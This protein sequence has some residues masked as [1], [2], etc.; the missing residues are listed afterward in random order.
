MVLTSTLWSFAWTE[1]AEAAFSRL[2]VLFTTTP[3]L[4]HPDPAHQF[5]VEVDASD[6]GVGA[7]LLQQGATD[8]K[9]HLCAFFS[10]WL[11]PAEHN[12][13]MGNRELLD[14]ELALQE[15]RH[16][17]EGSKELFIVWTDHKN[18]SYMQG[19]KQLNSWQAR[20]ALFPVTF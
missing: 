15:W 16:C 9:L 8:Q 12:Y 4:S 2:K 1:E 6:T 3:V 14:L 13:D 19:T 7:V 18:V 20:W 11:S 5:V 10:R 17:L